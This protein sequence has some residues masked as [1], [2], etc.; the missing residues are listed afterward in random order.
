MLRGGA[1][2]SSLEQVHLDLGANHSSP[3]AWVAHSSAP[4]RP[5][6]P[7]AGR[8]FI[9]GLFGNLRILSTQRCGFLTLC[10]FVLLF[11]NLS[12][13]LQH[14]PSQPALCDVP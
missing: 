4:W 1:L 8:E 3:Q 11:S 14:Q 9:S 5:Q 13:L 6:E 10:L 7:E 2:M 12:L